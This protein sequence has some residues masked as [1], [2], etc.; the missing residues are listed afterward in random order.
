MLLVR[1]LSVD[2]KARAA[3]VDA[4]LDRVPD[5]PPEQIPESTLWW[6][7]DPQLHDRFS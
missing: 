1:A 2:E 7:N 6:K 5:V 3:D 4:E